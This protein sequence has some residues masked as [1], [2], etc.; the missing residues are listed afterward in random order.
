MGLKATL[1]KAAASATSPDKIRPKWDWKFVVMSILV[2]ST[3][4]IKS[5]QNGIERVIYLTVQQYSYV[6]IKS[7]QN[8]I[9]S[10]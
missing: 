2:K 10:L 1:A 9:E 3:G 7:D 4:V 6:R 5:D 8:G